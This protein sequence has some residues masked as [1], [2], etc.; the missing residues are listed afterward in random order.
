MSDDTKTDTDEDTD[1]GSGDDT[2]TETDSGA[3]DSQELTKEQAMGDEDVPQ[4]KVDKIEKE[5]EERLDPDNRPEN[6][7]VD[8]SDREFDTKHGQFKDADHDEK[9]GPFNVPESEDGDAEA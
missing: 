9:L 2:G 7:E 4:E 6:A 1:G 3:D 8:N 5:R